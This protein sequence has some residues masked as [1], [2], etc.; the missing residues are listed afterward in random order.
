MS[1]SS[2]PVQLLRLKVEGTAPTPAELRVLKRI[3]LGDSQAEVAAQLW[4]REETVRKHLK[5]VRARLGARTTAQ[6]V[7]IAVSRDLI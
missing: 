4:V 2:L 7:A 5:V 1:A 6:A 3:A